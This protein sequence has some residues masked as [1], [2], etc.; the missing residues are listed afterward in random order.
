MNDDYLIDDTYLDEPPHTLLQ[1]EGSE[2]DQLLPS[3]S[4]SSFYRTSPQT[5]NPWD[6]RLLL[7]LAIAVEPLMH[8]LPRYGLDEAAYAALLDNSLFRKELAMMMRDVQENGATFKAKSRIQAEGYLPVIDEIIYNQETPSSIRLQAIQSV[9]KWG[10]L[11]PRPS[12]QAS[13]GPAS[14]INVQINF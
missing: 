14:Q 13:E 9:V 3:T 11:E 4:T 12:S 10:D 7:D 2:P 1:P 8:I 6:P 5:T